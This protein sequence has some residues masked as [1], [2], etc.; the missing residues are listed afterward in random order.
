MDT[1]P[2]LAIY[3]TLT[4]WIFHFIFTFRKRISCMA[5]MMAAMVLG[6]TIGLGVGT[7]FIIWFSGQPFQSIV[8]GTMVGGIVGALAGLPISVM[9]V[10]D[11]LLSGIMGGMMGTMLMMMLPE[12][13]ALATLKIVCVISSGVLFILF[14]ML[15][16][17]IKEEY[18]KQK[19]SILTKPQPLFTVIA[20][21]LLLIHQSNLL[22]ERTQTY[23]HSQMM[24][25]MNIPLSM[26]VPNPKTAPN[27]V[28]PTPVPEKRMVVKA[29][30]FSFF[31][32]LLTVNTGENVQMT[33]VN[34]GKVEHDFEIV[35]TDVHVHAGPGSKKSITFSL[36]QPG[37]YKAICTIP[38][39][40]EAGMISI[41]K[42]NSSSA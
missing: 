6:M 8:L 41:I 24:P 34:D 27:V 26:P 32:N 13:Y 5:G 39:H 37:E 2:F 36:K 3:S 9:A 23:A 4:A 10:L 31:P 16:G 28:Y 19:S 35:G 20:A 40:R 29:E 15:Q 14:L 7:L 25:K 12:V 17:E 11:G 1:W 33:F 18:L 38:G 30:E 42:V 22:P 21:F